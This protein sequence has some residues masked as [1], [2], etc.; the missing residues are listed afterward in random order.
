M[1]QVHVVIVNYQTAGLLRQ[2]LSHLCSSETAYP[3]TVTVVDNGSGDESAARVCA[4][5]PQVELLVAPRNLGFAGGN[6]L[7]LQPLL[8][9]LPAGTA[10]EHEYVLLLNTD[11]FVAPDTL[12]V[13][14]GFL[15]RH[16]RVGIVGPRV[17]KRDGSLDLACRRSFPT[18]ANAFYKLFGLARRFPHHPRFAAYNLTHRDPD[19]LTEVDAVVGA[20]ML[21]RV[22]A[23]DQAG[24]LDDRFFMYG[25]DLDWAY[26]IKAR[27]WRVFYCPFTRVLHYKGATSARQSGRMIVEFYRA[28]YLFHRKHYAPRLARPVNWMV[29]G[30]IVARGSLAL[31]TNTFRPA[32]KKRVA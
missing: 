11:L 16:P 18:P 29:T 19:E 13:L 10:R 15:E 3:Y 5:F 1:A 2:C 21:V 24:L 28:M 17:N 22:A 26:R 27:G 25:E 20:C 32:E 9:R 8:G 7:A 12:H 30:G 14:T 4:D 6:N 31:T 23:I